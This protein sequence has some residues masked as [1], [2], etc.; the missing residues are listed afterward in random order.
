M[1]IFYKVL[2]KNL[3]INKA[4]MEKSLW[5]ETVVKTEPDSEFQIEEIESWEDDDPKGDVP[6]N[7]VPKDDA[8]KNDDDILKLSQE[9]DL[10]SL[11]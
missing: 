6:I 4:P 8:L 2:Q 9:Q 11:S 1:I 10:F 5:Q 3:A 7:V